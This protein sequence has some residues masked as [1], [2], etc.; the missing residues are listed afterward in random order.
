M[1]AQEQRLELG[2]GASDG[3][4]PA[5][6]S[7]RWVP[8]R[9]P[10]T[11]WDTELGKAR[12]EIAA[13]VEMGAGGRP[14]L[15]AT[16]AAARTCCHVIPDGDALTRQIRA[17]PG[18][19]RAGASGRVMQGTGLSPKPPLTKLSQ[20]CLLLVWLFGVLRTPIPGSME[21]AL[22]F[23]PASCW[24]SFPFPLCCQG[25]AGA[26]PAR[27]C[28]RLAADAASSLGCS[29]RGRADGRQ[30]RSHPAKNGP[31]KAFVLLP[32]AFQCFQGIDGSSGSPGVM[33]EVS[34]PLW[35]GLGM[36]SSPLSCS[37]WMWAAKTLDPALQ[38]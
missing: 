2:E 23:R 16:Q 9:C 15:P 19:C 29:C 32:G 37:G 28:C 22:L 3:K 17:L 24:P 1:W 13:P 36:T 6:C 8:V 5:S 31:E 26:W 7:L 21:H 34:D 11:R 27:S 35:R 20:L 18:L 25:P 30:G 33:G 38:I 12:G 14:A 4:D 10:Q